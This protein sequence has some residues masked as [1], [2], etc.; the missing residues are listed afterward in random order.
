MELFS[1]SNCVALL[2][3]IAYKQQFLYDSILTLLIHHNFWHSK[4]SRK[5]PVERY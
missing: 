5:F 4:R 3:Q 2:L 1:P